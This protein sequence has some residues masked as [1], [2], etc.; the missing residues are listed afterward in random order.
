MLIVGATGHAGSGLARLLARRG[1]YRVSLGG[2]NESRAV[3]LGQELRD[4]DS[5]GE[6]AFFYLERERISAARLAECRCDVIVDC[7][8]PFEEGRARL[9]EAAIGARCHYLDIAGDR[10]FVHDIGRFDAP[11]RAAGIIA[12]SGAGAAPALSYAVVEA[13]TVAWLAIDSIDVALLPAP[14]APASRPAARALLGWAGQ[15]LNTFE[16]GRWQVGIGLSGQRRVVA[17]GLG[18]RRVGLADLPDLD[19]LPQRFSPRLRAR[20]ETGFAPPALDRAMRIIGGVARRTGP[21]AVRWLAGPL[22]ALAGWS[23]RFGAGGE[24]LVVDIAGRDMR[25]EVRVVRWSATGSPTLPGLLPGVAAA[26]LIEAICEGRSLRAGAVPATGLVRLEHMR[27]WLEAA[28][29]EI[30]QVAM[31]GEKPLLR[32]VLGSDFDR[33]PAPI[34]L[35]HRGRPAL[36]VDGECGVGVASNVLGRQLARWL[37]LPYEPGAAELRLVSESREGRVHLARS[38]GP[39]TLRS[40]Q[41]MVGDGVIEETCGRLVLRLTPLPVHGGLD[42]RVHSARVGWLPLPKRRI[43]LSE[44]AGADGTCAFAAAVG[45]PLIGRIAAWHGSFKP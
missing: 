19:L 15:D 31:K 36:I 30:R 16:E 9:I 38:F 32:R 33:L 2:R 29:M 14:G 22:V 35:A 1:G 28:S 10:R 25:G 4:I 43:A 42:Y 34:R 41:R 3:A 18:R 7:A 26:A 37:A 45:F 44:R 8:G 12:V 23:R 6:F 21:A 11:A 13:M 17:D 39:R 27:R 20:I 24:G 5:Q 40:T